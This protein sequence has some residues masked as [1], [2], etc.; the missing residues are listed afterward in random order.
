MSHKSSFP[1]SRPSETRI[2]HHT[3]FRWVAGIIVGVAVMAATVLGC[4]WPGTDHSVRFN[5]YR[6]AKEF[7]RLPPLPRDGVETNRLFS[8][9]KDVDPYVTEANYPDGDADSKEIDY[10]W[11]EITSEVDHGD[12]SLWELSAKT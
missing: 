8:W 5:F 12:G 1:L 10:L 6:T 2:L 3:Q 7:G 11:A 9:K 4:G